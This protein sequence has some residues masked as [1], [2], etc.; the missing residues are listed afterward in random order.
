MT[1]QEVGIY[2]ERSGGELRVVCVPIRKGG[3]LVCGGRVEV[4]GQE[5]RET[6]QVGTGGTQRLLQ[7][8]Q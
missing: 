7:P 5:T 3:Y 2:H 4:Q 1:D 6:D 8:E